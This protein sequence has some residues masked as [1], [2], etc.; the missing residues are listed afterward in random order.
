VLVLKG[1]LG[2]IICLHVHKGEQIE[3]LQFPAREDKIVDIS[4]LKVKIADNITVTLANMQ[5][6]SFQNVQQIKHKL[7]IQWSVLIAI[8]VEIPQREIML[9]QKDQ[10]Y[11]KALITDNLNLLM[12][13]DQNYISDC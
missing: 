5:T 13:L 10:R 9:D 11:L 2:L 12:I 1:C 6:L 4:Y 3:T 8:T 7:K